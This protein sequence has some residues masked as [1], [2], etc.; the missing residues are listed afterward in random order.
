MKYLFT[1]TRSSK[2]DIFYPSTTIRR[3]FSR[4]F[5]R[6][7]QPFRTFST[8]LVTGANRGLGLA[9]IKELSSK[10]IK[11]IATSRE[12]N[13]NDPPYE[14]ENIQ[15]HQLDQNCS[16][17]IQKLSH[18]VSESDLKIDL[19]I[20]NAAVN[21][22]QRG[23][24]NWNRKDFL[25]V[26]S[27]N[28]AGPIEIIQNLLPHLRN[29][30]IINISSEAA[31]ISSAGKHLSYDYGP[32]KAAL[33]HINA[34]LAYDPIMKNHISIAL[35]PGW[36]RTDMGGPN[37]HFS[38]E[39]TALRTVLLAESLSEKHNGQFLDHQTLNFKT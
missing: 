33:N 24:E 10:G 25:N 16:D 39:E 23:L 35:H 26:F 20:N 9:L 5:S 34:T 32:S 19:L 28:S 27:T 3:V 11:V 37:A 18:H 17:S 38:A 15:W 2:V 7:L 22:H 4:F 14:N 30:I 29:A 13:R 8:A 36:I 6:S 12:D 1:T 21:S 31:L